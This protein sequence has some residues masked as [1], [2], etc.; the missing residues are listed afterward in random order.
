MLVCKG[1]GTPGKCVDTAGRPGPFVQSRM[2][3][4][5]SLVSVIC[6]LVSLSAEGLWA[7]PLRPDFPE[8]T[9]MTM[10]IVVGSQPT[11]T[12]RHTRLLARAGLVAMRLRG[13]GDE[14][15]TGMARGGGGETNDA[16]TG[17][18]F[19]ALLQEGDRVG[20]L[21]DQYLRG[22]AATKEQAVSYMTLLMSEEGF[23][24]NMTPLQL[25]QLCIK[26]PDLVRACAQSL[27]EADADGDAAPGPLEDLL[28]GLPEAID[29]LS[30]RALLKYTNSTLT[31]DLVGLPAG[32]CVQ[33]AILVLLECPALLQRITAA[34]M[35]SKE[36][37]EYTL[38]GMLLRRSPME[39]R[40]LKR[41]PCSGF[42]YE[43]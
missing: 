14:M 10:S 24:D 23:L 12:A 43:I 11:S 40:L 20:F 7:P 13:A 17:E 41:Y 32:A 22:D 9:P 36:R 8:H 16:G 27:P 15:D 18:L 6:G 3:R 29:A 33:D 34:D 31:K 35:W 1:V 21:A 5:V 19:D 38:L 37:T 28:A 39:A 26:A 30:L 2:R 4:R 25:L 42:I